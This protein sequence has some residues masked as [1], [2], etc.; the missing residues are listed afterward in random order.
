[1]AT[2]LPQGV[3]ALQAGLGKESHAQSYSTLNT[4]LKLALHKNFLTFALKPLRAL[5][6]QSF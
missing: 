6:S 3:A 1:M 2:L 4:K 5:P